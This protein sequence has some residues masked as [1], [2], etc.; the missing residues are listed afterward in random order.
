MFNIPQM[1]RLWNR[2]P[3]ALVHPDLQ[4]AVN[5]IKTHT[6]GYASGWEAFVPGATIPRTTGQSVEWWEGYYDAQRKHRDGCAANLQGSKPDQEPRAAYL[7]AGGL[8]KIEIQQAAS[9]E[10]LKL[11]R[12]FI[13]LLLTQDGRAT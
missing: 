10:Q 9:V 11:A 7:G 3:G 13:D 1:V 5:A 8:I 12:D 4:D 6:P 2:T